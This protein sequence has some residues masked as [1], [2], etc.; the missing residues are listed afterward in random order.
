MRIP[1]GCGNLYGEVICFTQASRSWHWH[2]HMQMTILDFEQCPTDACV[3]KL[4]DREGF[5]FRSSTRG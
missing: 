3:L 5:Y 2:V 4:I 1:E